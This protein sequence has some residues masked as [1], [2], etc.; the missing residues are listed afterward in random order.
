MSWLWIAIGGAAGAWSRYTLG[1]W[2]GQRC[3][4]AVP[5]PTWFINVSGSYLLG[6]IIGCASIL[7]EFLVHLLA[8]GFC[9]AFTTFS[10]FGVEALK[11][12]ESRNTFYFGVYIL[13]TAIATTVV[14]A[15]GLAAGK[16]LL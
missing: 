2:L 5:W 3:S 11:L 13:S 6:F 16:A 9:G 7:P 15:L 10:T 1:A 12:W 14:A 4:Q 8:I